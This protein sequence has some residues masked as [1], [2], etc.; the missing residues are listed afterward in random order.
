MILKKIFGSKDR[1]SKEAL[2]VSLYRIVQTSLSHENLSIDS[3]LESLT[4]TEADVD[5]NHQTEVTIAFMFQAIVVVE[6]H[7]EYPVAGDVIDSMTKE[8]LSHTK[9]MGGTEEQVLNMFALYKK[10]LQEYYDAERN[11]TGDGPAYWMGKKFYENL[12]G[13]KVSHI[14]DLDKEADLSTKFKFLIASNHLTVIM[15]GLDAVVKG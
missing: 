11:Q 7:Y 3:L 8:F 6:K 4:L 9:E 14:D 10:R 13:I 1:K 2:G 5:R 12:T 15:G